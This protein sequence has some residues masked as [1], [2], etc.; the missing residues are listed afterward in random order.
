MKTIKI[1]IP[2]DFTIDHYLKLGQL[3]HLREVEKV[4]RV[5]SSVSGIEED[6]IKSWDIKSINKI[7]TDIQSIFDNVQPVFLPIFEWK[8]IRY[9][10]QPISKMSGAEY[11]DLET[12]LEK[13]NLLEVMAIIYRPIVEDKF[14]NTWWKIKK[15]L[16]YVAGKTDDLFKYYK[17]EKYDNEKRD[18]RVDIF[19]DLPVSLAIGAYNFFL[20]VGIQSL[21]NSLQSSQQVKEAEKMVMKTAM[22][23]LF[24]NIGGGLALST[25]LQ[26]MEEYLDS[27]EKKV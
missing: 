16:K 19:K 11:I 7:Y 14:D 13:G 12:R 3:E 6:E 26:K 9:G 23:N 25:D 22:E 5:I 18:W 1:E 15:Q 2:T 20:L 10:L 27:Q 4:V 24:N 8:G 17:V 21:N